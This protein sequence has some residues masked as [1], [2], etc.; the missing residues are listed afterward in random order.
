[1]KNYYKIFRNQLKWKYQKKAVSKNFYQLLIKGKEVTINKRKWLDL[2]K[3]DWFNEYDINKIETRILIYE[4][5]VNGWF[6]DVAKKLMKDKNNDLVV[7]QIAISYIEGNQQYR[8]GK[9]SRNSSKKCFIRGF[10][11]I[12]K[13]SNNIISEKRLEHFYD[14]VRCGLFHDGMIKKDVVVSRDFDA[15]LYLR[16]TGT[17]ERTILINPCKFLGII[18]QD[19]YKYIKELKSGNKESISNFEKY[20]L[21]KYK[22]FDFAQKDS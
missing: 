14:Q 12:F 8:E 6:L 13:I 10:R 4:D 11:R 19:F 22:T 18:S 1:M 3:P 17:K 16:E 9:P 2:N 5:Q 21:E 15:A 20:T 7:L